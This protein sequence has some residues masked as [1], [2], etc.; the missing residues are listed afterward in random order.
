[1]RAAAP[2]GPW[3]VKRSPITRAPWTGC[4]QIWSV[5]RM[6]KAPTNLLAGARLAKDPL[7][8]N[9]VAREKS[10]SRF[11][12]F[13]YTPGLSGAQNWGRLLNRL[14]HR[15]PHSPPAVC[16]AHLPTRFYP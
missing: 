10:P 16:L 2:T 8:S 5:H 13:A 4:E 3:P 12:S 11:V 14:T 15:R 1:M 7:H 9:T 6:D